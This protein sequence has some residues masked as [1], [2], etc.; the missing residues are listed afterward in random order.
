MMNVK[1]NLGRQSNGTVFSLPPAQRDWIRKE[2]DAHTAKQLFLADE[3]QTN[4][5]DQYGSVLPCIIVALLGVNEARL[6]TKIDN[7]E[8]VDPLSGQVIYNY[9]LNA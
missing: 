2:F 9:P 5:S 4:F 1:I 8:I 3:T 6:R 7:V